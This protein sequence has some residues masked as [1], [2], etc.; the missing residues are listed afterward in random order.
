MH[1]L[2]IISELSEI[3]PYMS[4]LSVVPDIFLEVSHI[5]DFLEK[6]DA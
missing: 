6:I 4:L 1:P 3:P 2:K 5:S